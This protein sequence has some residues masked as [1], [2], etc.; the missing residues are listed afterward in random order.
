MS[1]KIIGKLI[2]ASHLFIDSEKQIQG[3]EVPLIF[4]T[5]GGGVKTSRLIL[6]PNYKV[7]Y[8]IKYWD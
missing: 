6:R 3:R 7:R 5:I 1:E 4:E 2:T 8:K